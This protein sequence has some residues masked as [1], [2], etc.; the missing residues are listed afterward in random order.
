MIPND[1]KKAYSLL[2]SGTL[3]MFGMVLFLGFVTDALFLE[4]RMTSSGEALLAPGLAGILL[5]STIIIWASSF[6][7]KLSLLAKS[8]AIIDVK[9]LSRGPFGFS[10]HPIYFGMIL[11]FLGLSFILNSVPM[12]L[13]TL[14]AFLTAELVFIPQEEE[15]L[16]KRWEDAY[17]NYRKKV[18]R[19]I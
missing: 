10:R 8:G 11:M 1:P 19:W 16:L 9:F 6:G 18:H 17:A 13:A 12:L 2:S 5:G 14:V 4:A 15:L 7:R 3:T